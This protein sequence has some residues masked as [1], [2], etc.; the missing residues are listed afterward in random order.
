MAPM[1]LTA[2]ESAFQPE[3]AQADQREVGVDPF[4]DGVGGQHQGPAG[5]RHDGRVVADPQLGVGGGSRRPPQRGG[6]PA[7]GGLLPAAGTIGSRP[8]FGS[9]HG[10]MPTIERCTP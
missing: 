8:W 2:A 6:D 10:F 3:V 9:R 7:D 4:D 1:S 5:G